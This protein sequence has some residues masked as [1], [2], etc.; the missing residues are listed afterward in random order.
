ML[1]ITAALSST[2]NAQ[3]R[4]QEKAFFA[5]NAAVAFIRPGFVITINSATVG[6]DGTISTVFSVTDPKGVPLD[7][8][9][10]ETPG[11]ISVSFLAAF[12]PKGKDQYTSYTIRTV[13]GAVLPSTIQ[14][15]ADSGGVSGVCR[16]DGVAG[17]GLQ[18]QRFGS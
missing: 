17:D 9:G 11:P 10:V 5:D 8:L 18:A 4:M 1:L 7:R 12:I 3:F 2:S 13:S 14:A 15:G 6:A 16:G